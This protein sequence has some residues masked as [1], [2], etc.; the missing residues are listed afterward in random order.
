MEHD[1]GG[2]VKNRDYSIIV[3]MAGLLHDKIPDV[4]KLILNMLEN[5][6]RIFVYIDGHDT[7]ISYK[8]MESVT[9]IEVF[10]EERG[11][12]HNYYEAIQSIPDKYTSMDVVCFVD[13]DD[14]LISLDPVIRE[15]ENDDVWI[16]H[17]S[18]ITLSGNIGLFNGRY[19]CPANKV[20]YAPWRGT[21]LKTARLGLLRKLRKEHF[22]KDGEWLDVSSD[23]AMMFPLIE[24]AGM[25]HVRYIPEDIYW[26]NDLNPK[27]DHKIKGKRQ[28]EIERW[29]RRCPVEKR[30][31]NLV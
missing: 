19:T 27:N 20:R 17:G 8:N 23:M 15:Y 11:A 14:S 5:R 6:D 18:Y 16:T 31:L 2:L 24:M 4:I 9:R 28:K 21:H 7:R 3:L 1:G 13:L 22:Q 25:E 30:I 10:N 29:L 12:A 26:Y